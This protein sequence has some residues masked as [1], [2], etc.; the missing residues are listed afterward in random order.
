MDNQS[1]L[2]DEFSFLT[3]TDEDDEI[4]EQQILELTT[5]YIEDKQYEK[6]SLL[7]INKFNT[8]VKNNDTIGGISYKTV[9]NNVE[10]I[11]TTVM[12]WKHNVIHLDNNLFID[13]AKEFSDYFEIPNTIE[14]I[15]ERQQF[16]IK[17]N[18][19]K[20]LIISESVVVIYSCSLS[21]LSYLEVLSIKKGSQLM[22]LYPQAFACINK[23]RKV[24]LRNAVNIQ[25]LPKE[26]FKLSPV[27][28]L[29]LNGAIEKV[30]FT[31]LIN[32]ELK[33][34]IIEYT[35]LSEETGVLCTKIHK[36]NIVELLKCEVDNEGYLWFSKGVPILPPYTDKTEVDLEKATQITE[37]I[38]EQS[39]YDD[40]A[41]WDNW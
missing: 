33:E 35:G 41:G 16:D 23:L 29:K 19:I 15:G 18:N 17:I 3:F 31:N 14:E 38:K 28:Q 10:Q 8:L 9:A 25:E 1:T 27:K 7:L 13:I 39:E 6:D 22:V 4:K 36:Y 30:H 21:A 37:D 40:Y 12:P 26:L 20:Q 24:D 2:L 11:E 34:F 5:Q 32:P